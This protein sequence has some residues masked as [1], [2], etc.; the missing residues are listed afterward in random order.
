MRET[1]SL[2]PVPADG[3]RRNAV[4]LLEDNEIIASMLTALLKS[5]SLRVIWCADSATGERVFAERG[6]EVL[7]VLADCRLPDGDGRELCARFRTRV[8]HLPVLVTSGSVS[9]RGV[10]PL[11]RDR[12]VEYLPKPYAPAEVITRVRRLMEVADGDPVMNAG[13]V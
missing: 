8:P 2:P 6:G 11:E 1:S 4:L 10:A 7:L 3:P 5:L 12:F 13:M 9:G